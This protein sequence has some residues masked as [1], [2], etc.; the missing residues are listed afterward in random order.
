MKLL[1]RKWIGLLLL[2]RLQ[3]AVLTC[4]VLCTVSLTTRLGFV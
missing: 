3:A 1:E 2:V 4:E